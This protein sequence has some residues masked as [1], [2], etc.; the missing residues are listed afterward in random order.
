MDETGSVRYRVQLNTV[1]TRHE[2]DHEHEHEHEHEH[3][4][5]SG[6]TLTQIWHQSNGFRQGSGQSVVVQQKRFQVL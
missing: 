1:R 3:S 2:H 5:I 4:R 6:K